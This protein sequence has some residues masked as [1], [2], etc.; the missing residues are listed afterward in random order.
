MWAQW[1]HSDTRLRRERPVNRQIFTRRAVPVAV[2]LALGGG[3][4][5]AIYAATAGPDSSTQTIVA[6]V[7]A[8]PAANTVASTTNSLTQLYKNAV[9]G[10]VDITVTQGSSSS[11]PGG[12]SS[13]AEGSGFVV[14][15]NG[16]IVTNAHVVEGGSS[17]KVRFQ[18]GKTVNAT[19]VGT[20][21]ST[22]IAVIK[23]SVSASQLHPLTWGNSSSVQ[24]GQD[25]A[26]IGSPFGLQGTLT[27]GIVSALNRTIT[28]PN[29]YSIAGAIQTDAAINHGN[30]GGPLLN[31]AGDVIGVNAQIDSDSGGNDGVG[32]SISSNAAK[33]VSDTLI[34]GGKVQHAYLGIRV[35]DASNG[36][37]AEIVTVVSGSPADKAGLK[38]GDVITSIDG[39]T[40]ENGDA[41]TAAV[42]AHKPSDVVSVNVTRNGSSKTVKVTLG[43]RP[44]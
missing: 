27:A 26:A 28:A 7:P 35:S 14:D 33:S 36:G 5:A 15:T 29:N 13:Q 16:D 20:D 34:S 23:V 3:A 21:E 25:V 38:A 17:I 18:T 31:T 9:P 42:A 40:I 2:A 30:S 1:A 22:D 8:S 41:L 39:T 19:L 37:G 32:F 43:V 6:S 44:A 12:G 10:V 11:T 24:V 4:G